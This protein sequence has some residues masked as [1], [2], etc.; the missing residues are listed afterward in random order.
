M[1]IYSM[2]PEHFTAVY[3]SAISTSGNNNMTPFS[4]ACLQ[5]LASQLGDGFGAEIV[6]VDHTIAIWNHTNGTVT[7]PAGTDIPTLKHSEWD[8]D[9]RIIFSRVS[10]NAISCIANIVNISTGAN[11][12]RCVLHA[13]SGNTNDVYFINA[14]NKLKMLYVGDAAGR[15]TSM[16]FKDDKIIY[17]NGGYSTGSST[18]STTNMTIYDAKNKIV[19][20]S[21]AYS[22]ADVIDRCLTELMKVFYYDT[23]DGNVVIFDDLFVL[24]RTTMQ[25][26]NTDFVF[27]NDD[28]LYSCAGRSTNSQPILVISDKNVP[29]S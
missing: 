17:S 27:K 28:V 19:L 9:I 13:T 2:Y 21:I 5:E 26:V 8:S 24:S 22:C 11:I 23:S 25:N 29:R 1:A 18:A 12:G 14:S 7:I 20:S 3:G 4:L 15:S 10:G 6:N 16:V